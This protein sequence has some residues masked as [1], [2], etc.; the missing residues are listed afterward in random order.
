M[1]TLLKPVAVITHH[2]G[3][4]TAPGTRQRQLRLHLVR[5]HFA[6]TRYPP[7]CPSRWRCIQP[8]YRSF[9][10]RSGNTATPFI[11][12]I[13]SPRP[14]SSSILGALFVVALLSRVATPVAQLN[15][16]TSPQSLW[17]CSPLRSCQL[18]RLA[19]RLTRPSS[20]PPLSLTPSPVAPHCAHPIMWSRWP[21]QVV[22]PHPC[23]FMP[24][25]LIPLH[26]RLCPAPPFQSHC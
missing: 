2:H 22:P 9:P 4:C 13:L 10:S 16:I 21:L 18:P 23:W 20:P 25:A 3:E 26:W 1:E 14:V 11:A 7:C 5:G 24:M 19:R 8:H 12:L 6:I 15:G 17:R